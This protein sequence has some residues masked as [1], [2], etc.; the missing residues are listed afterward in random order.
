MRADDAHL[1][2]QAIAGF[3]EKVG[4][5]A[6]SFWVEPPGLSDV[7]RQTIGV[8]DGSQIVFPLAV[9]IGSYTGPVYGASGVTSVYLDGVAQAGG[10]SVSSDYLPAIAFTTA[11]GTGV[12]VTA[13]FN[14]LWLCRFADDVQDLEEFMTMLWALRTVRLVTGRP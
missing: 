14:L 2:L 1:E 12:A 5:A 10:W 9:S 6:A 11:P 7:T 3:F 13:D 8:G 4:G